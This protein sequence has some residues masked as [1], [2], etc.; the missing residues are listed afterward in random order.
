LPGQMITFV[1]GLV[2]WPVAPMHCVVPPTTAVEL[3]CRSAL[4]GLGSLA[5]AGV[6]CAD[7]A[8][9]LVLVVGRPEFFFCHQHKRR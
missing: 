2:R 7:G 5:V 3:T 4:P 6:E 8:I 1:P 9:V